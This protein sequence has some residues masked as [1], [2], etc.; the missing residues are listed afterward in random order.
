MESG[1]KPHKE[2]KQLSFFEA[3]VTA[4]E[5][6]QIVVA[7][8]VAGGIV[9]FITYNLIPL[10]DNKHIGIIIMSLSLVSGACLATKTVRSH[11]KHIP[12][13]PPGEESEKN[14]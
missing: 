2:A 13:F 9:C 4:F 14:N 8:L 7:V 3:I 5:W 10:N 6:C 12:K 11:V 1:E